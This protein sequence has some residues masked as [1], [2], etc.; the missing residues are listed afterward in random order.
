MQESSVRS[1]TD[2]SFPEQRRHLLFHKRSFHR[3]KLDRRLSYWW[4]IP[5]LQFELMPHDTA[6]IVLFRGKRLFHP[7]H[8]LK[9]L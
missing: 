4:P 9:V 3:A 7:N 1:H 6:D 8:L 5:D 2:Y